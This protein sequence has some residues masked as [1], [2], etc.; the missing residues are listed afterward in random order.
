MRDFDKD[1]YLIKLVIQRNNKIVRQNVL[2]TTCETC[3]KC[4][5]Y[6]FSLLLLCAL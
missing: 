2:N 6:T 5:D 1:T 4:C 3:E